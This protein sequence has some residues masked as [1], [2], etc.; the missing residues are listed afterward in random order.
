MNLFFP[1][2]PLR[3]ILIF[4][5]SALSLVPA[6]AADPAPEPAGSGMAQ[7]TSLP[8]SYADRAE[9][10][11]FIERMAEKHYFDR[12]ALAELFRQ[13]RHEPEV[14][15]AILPPASP[16]A[17]S[18]HAYRARFIETRRIRKGLAFRE[19]HAET[20]KK[21]EERYG[22]PA[23]I[24]VAIIGIETF[25][26]QNMGHYQT[27]SAL[28][29][30]AFDYPPRADLFRGELE[31]LLLL[32]REQKADPL[33]YTGSFAGAM[34]LPQFLPSSLR[35]YAVD[36][37]D[38]GSIDLSGDPEDAIGSVAS[39][40]AAHGWQK[41]GLV[42]LPAHLKGTR[43]REIADGKVE[44][45]YTPAELQ[46]HGI[47]AP[48]A[49]APDEK[50]FLIDLATPN[51]ATEYWLG[52]QN[53]YVITRYNRSSFYAMSVFQLAEKIRTGDVTGYQPP[54]KKGKSRHRAAGARSHRPHR[55]G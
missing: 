52:L 14:L 18:W 16:A 31:A 9:V 45:R 2:Q 32:A 30:L 33:A 22:V 13:A 41:D 48:A 27:F 11:R 24:I 49:L 42:T 8:A 10:R 47:Q 46:A 51:K 38:D 23:D 35:K 7:P 43:Y 54:R 5:L 4:L 55:R 19:A 3:S 44:P 1:R 29:N 12:E 21:A 17:R 20:L 53:F 25:Y 34:G 6:L 28:T 36:F 50:T 40:L 15:E 26:G 37:N 39:F